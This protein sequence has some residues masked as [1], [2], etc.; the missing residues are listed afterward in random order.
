MLSA[1]GSAFFDRVGERF[2]DAGFGGRAVLK[3]LRSGC[4]LT[5]D[6]LGYD[7]AYRADPARN[8]ASTC[9]PAAWRRRWRSGPMSSP[10]PSPAAP[11]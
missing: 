9:R 1:G 6:T 8:L 2:G 10:G 11:S 4:Y 3:V 5:H 7:A